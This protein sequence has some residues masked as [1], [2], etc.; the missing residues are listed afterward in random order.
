[1]TSPAPLIKIDPEELYVKQE[2]IGR[3]SFGEV[4]KGFDKRNKAPV[5]IKII[6]LEQAED[7]IEDIQQEIS[8]LSQLDSPFVTKYYGS[9]I[10]GSKLWIVM[11]FC[12][13]G[14]CLDLMKPGLFE[15]LFIAIILRELLKGLEY[16]HDQNKLHRDIKAANILLTQTGDVKLADFGVSGQLTATMTKKNTFVGTPFWMAPEVIL[17]SGYNEKADIWSLGIT[18]IELAKGEPPHADVHPMRVL[19][20]IPKAEPPALDGAFSRAFKEFVSLC[21]QKDPAL[22]PSAKDLLKHRFIK[23]AKKC[24]FL[25]ELT[26]RYERWR[27]EPGNAGFGTNGQNTIDGTVIG[28]G[29]SGASGPDGG[30]GPHSAMSTVQGATWDFSTV[31]RDVAAA[32]AAAG[33]AGPTPPPPPVAAR[34]PASSPP[35]PAAAPAPVPPIQPSYNA[36]GG[37]GAS[38]SAQSPSSPQYSPYAI[39]TA[40]APPPPPPSSSSPAATP[41]PHVRHHTHSGPTSPLPPPGGPG[42]PAMPL[43]HAHARQQTSPLE[44]SSVPGGGRGPAPPLPA[45]PPPVRPGTAPLAPATSSSNGNGPP[46]RAAPP[47]PVVPRPISITNSNAPSASGFGGGGSGTASPTPRPMSAQPPGSATSSTNPNP[48]WYVQPWVQ[49]VAG[50]KA[51]ARTADAARGLDQLRGALETLEQSE[52][53]EYVVWV[54]QQLANAS[55]AQQQQPGHHAQYQQ[56]GY[57]QQQQQ[58]QAQYRQHHPHPQQHQ[59]QQGNG[60]AV[61]SPSHHHAPPVAGAGYAPPGPGMGPRAYG[62][63]AGTQQQQ[64]QYLQQQRAGYPPQQ[65][66]PHDPAAAPV[67]GAPG[68]GGY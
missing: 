6:D 4:F 16:L 51:K 61:V 56:A 63:P 36:N 24:S 62:P 1:M 10:K 55:S 68:A 25:T 31:R 17:Q 35:A 14:S 49:V 27:S 44:L 57:Q 19:F 52:G 21:L 12:G 59:Q 11:E 29:H 32:A 8:I 13:G 18:A 20:I 34:P 39:T 43:P 60:Y 5:A 30:R 58:Q 45:N 28:P 46:Y 15:E 2:R 9:F 33:N 23:T 50:L 64:Q 66:Q 22:R 26:E 47:P 54:C 67:V 3:G 37:G 40:G 42:A 48:N 65:Q 38:S 7:E 53:T 41:A